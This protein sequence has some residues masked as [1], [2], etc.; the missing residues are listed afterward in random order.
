MKIKV[1]GLRDPENIRKLIKILPDYIGFIF[2]EKS[3]RY[4]GENKDK[5]MLKDIPDKIKKVGVFVNEPIQIVKEKVIENDL[6]LVQLHGN[7]TPDYCKK[8]SDEGVSIIK[9]FG[10][11]EYFDMTD[12][13][14]YM[15][16]CRYFL[17]D[18]K[19]DSYGGSG[20][21]FNHKVLEGYNYDKP[22]ILSGGIGPGDAG[23]IR[24]I[25]EE[26]SIDIHAVDI[27]SRFETE[28]GMKDITKVRDFI[29]R[30]R[31]ID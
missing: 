5:S 11:D 27:N 2:Y 7:E 21:K 29:H 30:I 17:F 12:T 14:S 16:F 25:S 31:E 10:V 13:Q 15:S 18:T 9:A 20:K 19:S 6:D 26:Y 24:K 22:V 4:V 23:E 1:C 3:K 8:L 28:P